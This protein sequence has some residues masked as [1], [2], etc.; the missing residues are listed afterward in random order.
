[1]QVVFRMR[2]TIF[3]RTAHGGVSEGTG[4]G[5]VMIAG[6]IT[7]G[8]KMAANFDLRLNAGIAPGSDWPRKQ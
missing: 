2:K 4:D 7:A 8:F 5:R 6:S 3:S 1:M